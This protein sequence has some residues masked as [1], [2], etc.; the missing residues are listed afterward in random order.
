MKVHFTAIWMMTI[1]EPLAWSTVQ[2]E[3]TQGYNPWWS[4]P[5]CGA[6]YRT[7]DYRLHRATAHGDKYTPEMRRQLLG[8][9]DRPVMPPPV[10]VIVQQTTIVKEPEA[11]VVTFVPIREREALQQPG[12]ARTEGESPPAALTIAMI[13]DIFKSSGLK[14]EAVAGGGLI[15]SK[16]REQDK[17]I[18]V[19]RCQDCIVYDAQY[20][21]SPASS[22][23]T[24]LRIAN[25]IDG[26]TG[27]V[28]ARREIVSNAVANL[29]LTYNLP[30]HDET[31]GS[32]VME[33]VNKM[34]TGITITRAA[35]K[36]GV[37]TLVDY[38][39]DSMMQGASGIETATK[40]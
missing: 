32:E 11:P 26:L 28:R 35:D 40:E 25:H 16:D 5:D 29:H 39:R 33:G 2:G 1:I 18:R 22:E 24:Q 3:T 37:L 7:D 31:S 19:R 38:R 30:L 15:V 21:F 34:W 12:E 36:A 23:L 13:G 4:C 17:I 6:R 9:E 8:E 20:R 27:D 14:V 10:Q